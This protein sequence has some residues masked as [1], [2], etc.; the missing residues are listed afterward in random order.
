[1][2]SPPVSVLVVDD[3]AFMRNLI[4]RIVEAEPDMV[5]AGKAMNGLF[6]LQKL[7]KL[8]PD[9]IILD[10]E[11]P[12]MNGI[13]FL[14]ERRKQ[15]V[16]IPVVILS[17]LVERGAR[18]TM[19][20]LALGASDF[21]L[22]PSGPDSEDLHLIAEQLTHMIRSYGRQYQNRRR[23][24]QTGDAE[25]QSPPGAATLPGSTRTPQNPA[26]LTSSA[27]TVR[28]PRFESALPS[29]T[30]D[31]AAPR[32]AAPEATIESLIA[33]RNAGPHASEPI[34]AVAIGIST[35]GP[36]AL[37]RVFAE[38]D[39]DL[40][41]PVLVVQHM[42]AGFTEEFARSLDRICPLEVREAREGDLLKPG[43]ILIAAGDKHL[44]VEKLRLGV[45]ARL[46]DEAAVNGHRPSV[47]V[48]FDSVAKVFGAGTLAVIMTGMGRDGAQNLGQILTAG[49]VTI[50]QDQASS[51]VYGMP[52]VAWEKGHVQLQ[53]PL[54]QVSGAISRLAREFR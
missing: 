26:Q 43:R 16:E 15:N 18:V 53:M 48:L 28:S 24:L 25:F 30:E 8:A 20:A 4:G 38:I 14:E 39:P 7:E 44:R 45:V 11:M 35:G 22:K 9:I 32:R 41:L 31:I 3:S 21:V 29:R 33:A 46:G 37:R 17:S 2:D 12:E 6:A 10:I 19:T 13:E 27:P 51:I 5:L 54:D 50:G 49:G 40:G 47:D 36:N 42:P 34:A 23:M 1:V 52:R